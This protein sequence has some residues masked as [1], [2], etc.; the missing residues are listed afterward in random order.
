MRV[1]WRGM[2]PIAPI[3]RHPVGA[4]TSQRPWYPRDMSGNVRECCEDVYDRSAYSKTQPEEPGG[5]ERRGPTASAGVVVGT[6]HRKAFVVRLAAG[7]IPGNR[8]HYLGF[9]VLKVR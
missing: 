2:A 3:Q 4:K 9:R 1:A 8:D 5:Y 6:A 7:A